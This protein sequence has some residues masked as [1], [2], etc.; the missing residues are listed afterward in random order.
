MGHVRPCPVQ[1]SG[2]SS[3]PHSPTGPSIS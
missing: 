1:D 2:C 3:S